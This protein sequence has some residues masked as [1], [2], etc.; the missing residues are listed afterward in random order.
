MDL[1]SL[2]DRAQQTINIDQNLR[3]RLLW[4]LL[5]RVILYTLLLGISFIFQ[6]EQFD[7][8]VLPSNLLV[9]LLFSIYLITIFFAFFLL[10]FLGNLRKFGFI[11]IL[12]DTF[13][14]TALVFFSGSSNSIFTSVYFFPIIAGGLIL[15]KRG[16]LLAAAASSLQYG[17]LLALEI[18][19]F[20][21]DYVLEFIFFAPRSTAVII[22]H[23]AIH[24]LTFFLAAALSTV[25]GIRLKTTEDALN[26]SIKKFDHLTTL[27]KQIFDNITTG[28]VT[29]DNH[30]IITSAN[31]AIETITGRTA[32][33]MIGEELGSL[34]PHLDL[35]RPNLRLTTNFT[36]TD[37]KKIRIGYAHIVIESTVET[38]SPEDSPQKIITLRDISDIEKLEKQVRQTEKLAAIGM[39]SASIA[40][41]FRNP[42]AAISGSAQLLAN[43][44]TAGNP[45]NN[46]NYK[47]T[48]I[49]LRESTR[50]IDTIGD[51]LKF[52]RPEHADKTWFSLQN[53]LDEVLQVCRADP[54]WPPTCEIKVTI[55]K[56]LDIWADEKLLFTAFIH[57]VHNGLAF[58]PKGEEQITITAYEIETD[59]GEEAVEI[60]ISDNGPGIPKSEREEQI[61][62]PFFTSRADGTG[63]GLAI[64]QQTIRAHQGSIRVEDAETGGAL[65]ILTL[66]LP[67]QPE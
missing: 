55:E 39:M 6:G 13:F 61:F 65:F 11:Q 59:A 20:Y 4:M 64:V 18:Y 51:F 44:F 16:G 14:V 29:I 53:C 7:V 38:V 17:F 1:K 19:G 52:S 10:I 42:L 34:F 31:N 67:S 32:I 57:L 2:T 60:S 45:G 63:L 46:T 66:P 58:C 54:T 35:S 24:G 62:E 22:N 40:H 5:L 9:L 36:K 50:L 28:I 23:F 25:F 37:G 43:D 21:P 15:P 30:H 26:V 48:N 27:Y 56:T 33:A 3:T 47:L 41:D 8:I 12:L 49:I